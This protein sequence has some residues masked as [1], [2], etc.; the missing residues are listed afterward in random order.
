MTKVTYILADGTKTN[1]YAEAQANK[2]YTVRYEKIETEPIKLT[3]KRKA[4]RVKAVA[5]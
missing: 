2:P 4:I 1:S 3:E 5:R